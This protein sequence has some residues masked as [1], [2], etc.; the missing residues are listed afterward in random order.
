MNSAFSASEEDS[1]ARGKEELARL[2]ERADLSSYLPSQKL[3]LRVLEIEFDVED[4]A[5]I[6]SEVITDGNNDKKIDALYLD[7][8]QSILVV[9][10]GYWNQSGQGTAKANKASD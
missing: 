4:S 1:I 9:A 5:S 7:V 3:I 6:G 10:Q 8:D 2:V